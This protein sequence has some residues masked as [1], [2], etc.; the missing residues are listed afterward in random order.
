MEKSLLILSA[1]LSA[2]ATA[3]AQQPQASPTPNEVIPLP[4]TTQK[5]GSLGQSGVAQSPGLAEADR[6]SREVVQLYQ[7]GKLDEAL[8]PAERAL[9]LREAVLGAYD[10]LVARALSNLA[11]VLDALGRTDEARAAYERALPIFEFKLG[12]DD[13]LTNQT[14]EDL[15]G[16]DFKKHDYISARDLLE[17]ALTSREKTLGADHKLVARTLVDLGFV[18]LVTGDWRKRDATFRRLLDL[19]ARVPEQLPDNV[20]EL[21]TDYVCTGATQPSASNEQKEIFGLI[22]QL[23]YARRHSGQN[24]V[25]GGVLNG[26]AISRSQP[27][28]PIT[29]RQARAQGAV[30]VR[31]LVDDAGKVVEAT[32]VCGPSLLKDAAASAARR[33]RFSPTLLNGVPVKVT[34][35]ITFNFTLQ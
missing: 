19:Q 33:W 17:R 18:Y 1:V 31:V 24:V 6:L 10:P 13:P 30:L 7:A 16:L 2:C 32:P 14:R 28:Y 11:G 12:T 34:G 35:T 29:A 5:S 3:S 25:S 26:K 9:K 8:P 20:K 15:A 22:Q 27:D 21:F 23:E 4:Q